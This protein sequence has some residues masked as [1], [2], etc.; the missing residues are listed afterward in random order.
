MRE[1][2]NENPVAQIALI[3]VLVVVVG[4]LFLH[5]FGGSGGGGGEESESAETTPAAE[6]RHLDRSAGGESGVIGSEPTA[7]DHLDAAA[8]WQ[9]DAEGDDGRVQA[10]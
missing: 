4:F 8:E 7:A 1:K 5:G 6:H 9:H 2:L 3:G 10:R